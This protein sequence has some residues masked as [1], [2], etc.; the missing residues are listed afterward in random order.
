MPPISPY[1]KNAFRHFRKATILGIE[2]IYFRFPL[3]LVREQGT[4]GG[5]QTWGCSYP[6]QDAAVPRCFSCAPDRGNHS[7]LPGCAVVYISKLNM[8]WSAS[9]A[10]STLAALQFMCTFTFSCFLQ[11]PSALS[12][13]KMKG[14]YRKTLLSVLHWPLLTTI[15]TV[16]ETETIHSAMVCL[17]GRYI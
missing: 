6:A 11:P 14:L 12:A 15:V 9:G 1:Y 16:G 10:N 5:G 13:F 3:E 7:L 8:S 4:L 17:H 2:S